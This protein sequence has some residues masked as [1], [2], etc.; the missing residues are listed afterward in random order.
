LVLQEQR[1]FPLREQ[2]PLDRPQ[3]LRHA[4]FVGRVGGLRLG[5]LD[6]SLHDPAVESGR[7]AAGPF[8][9]AGCIAPRGDEAGVV[10]LP[11]ARRQRRIHDRLGKAVEAAFIL[12]GH[13]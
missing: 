5:E 8:D 6:L 1:P 7:D 11:L 3:V 12:I 10:D 2:P 4:V 9:R 13:G